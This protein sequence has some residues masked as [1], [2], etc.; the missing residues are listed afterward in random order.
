M[1]YGAKRKYGTS[2]GKR[3]YGRSTYGG[4][5]RTK[6]ASRYAVKYRKPLGSRSM[7]SSR[8]ST[9]SK[10]IILKKTRE[11]LWGTLTS[12]A[13]G[14]GGWA[15][16]SITFPDNTGGTVTDSLVAGVSPAP[17]YA[18]GF[19]WQFANVDTPVGFADFVGMFEQYKIDKV[20]M[21]TTT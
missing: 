2:Y 6:G 11:F 15:A 5:A 16:G 9:G 8:R 21:S 1:A 17:V 10:S 3:S 12:G 7:T 13:I 18:Q 20:R 14:M 4:K 19:S